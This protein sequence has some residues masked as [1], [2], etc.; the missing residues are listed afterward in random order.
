MTAVLEKTESPITSLIGASSEKPVLE[1][2]RCGDIRIDPTYQRKLRES[3]LS[4]IVAEF[5]WSL[6]FA[7]GLSR[8]PDSSLWVFDGQHRVEAVL[9]LFGADE[10]VPAI[11]VSG[12][13]HEDEAHL[14]YALQTTRKPVT[15]IE[16]FR[17][18]LS[19]GEMAATEIERISSECGFNITDNAT[20]VRTIPSV[21]ALE[22]LYNREH[23]D[24]MLRDVLTLA[25]DIWRFREHI[26][27][28]VLTELAKVYVA[29]RS[30][31]TFNRER[32]VTAARV[33]PPIGWRRRS[34]EQRKAIHAL[35]A[36]EY[37]HR[38]PE[39]SRI[40]FKTWVPIYEKDEDG[41]R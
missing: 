38:L 35:I 22:S 31:K 9:S 26:P 11:V 29:G 24:R 7:V 41:R 25:A 18:Q 40:K 19:R 1:L 30:S 23:G 36:D 2:V 8:R 12:L 34:S 3:H 37:N 39:A 27:G 17:A 15:A 21:G 5:D 6:F 13:T 16:R 33:L 10:I 28:S 14:F 32:L 4:K 20:G